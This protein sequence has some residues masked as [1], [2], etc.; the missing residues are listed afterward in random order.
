MTKE[1]YDEYGKLHKALWKWLSKNP[2]KGKLEWPRWV[3]NGGDVSAITGEC[4]ACEVGR[5]Q[6]LKLYTSMCKCCPITWGGSTCTRGFFMLWVHTT[7][8]KTRAK[9]A[10]KIASLWGTGWK[11]N[12]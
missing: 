6:A 12:D 10:K 3:Y 9:L 1:Q 7:D 5:K 2:K 8:D 11:P 4:F